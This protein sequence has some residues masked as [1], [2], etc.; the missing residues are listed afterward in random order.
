[1]RLRP[2]RVGAVRHLQAAEQSGL[3]VRDEEVVDRPAL[4]ELQVDGLAR[5]QVAGARHHVRRGDAAGPRLLDP[6]VADVDRVARAHV[7]LYGRARVGPFHA[8]DVAVGVD[9]ARH[10]DLARGVDADGAGRDR[11]RAFR[12]DGHDLAL[13]DDQHAL[14]DLGPRDRDDARADDRERLV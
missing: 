13:L 12:A 8:A 4:A 14:R 5:E 7:G 1:R 10:Q 3:W 11:G 9:D 2:A 6:R